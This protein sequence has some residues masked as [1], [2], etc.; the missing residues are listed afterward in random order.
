MKKKTKYRS[1]LLWG[2]FANI[3]IYPIF[4]LLVIK[5]LKSAVKV[6]ICHINNGDMLI[7]LP[8]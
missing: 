1:E 6:Q 3:A 4:L 7:L 2:C 5:K 8:L